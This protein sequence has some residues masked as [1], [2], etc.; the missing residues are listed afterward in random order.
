MRRTALALVFIAAACA[1]HLDPRVV[2][3]R[4]RSQSVLTP[5]NS[6]MPD[7]RAGWVDGA[8]PPHPQRDL[9]VRV[10]LTKQLPSEPHI[11]FRAYAARMELFAGS[12]RIYRFDEPQARGHLRTHDV[13]LAPSAG[14]G[15]LLIRIPSGED[16][17]IGGEPVIAP[18]AAVPATI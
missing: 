2:L 7:E 11:V 16:L 9:W 18:E 3:L 13:S 14:G 15:W 6:P 8:Q 10:K 4:G 1:Q 12:Q 17:L 5:P